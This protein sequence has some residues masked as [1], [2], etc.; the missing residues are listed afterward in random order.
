MRFDNRRLVATVV[1]AVVALAACAPG[2][3]KSSSDDSATAAAPAPS[4]TD[5]T[6]PATS[7]TVRSDS[8]VLR[9]DRTQYKA[10]EKI[11]LTFQNRS[12]A[13]YAFNPCTR[14][15]EHEDAGTW[16]PMP[17]EGRMCT[18]EAWML[19]PHAT[20]TGDTELPATMAPGRYRVVV[21]MT[22]EGSGATPAAAITA[23]SDAI[24]VS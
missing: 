21:R 2:A 22:V 8:V 17:D 13:T 10:G 3:S 15:L 23:V 9:T 18:M 12:G 24:T 6:G 5:T 14:A 19:E 11:T 4:R 16:K 7:A 20:R 1:G